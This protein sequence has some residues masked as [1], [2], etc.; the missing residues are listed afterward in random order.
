MLFSVIVIVMAAN[1]G[2][3]VVRMIKTKDFKKTSVQSAGLSV[4]S[5]VLECI[6]WKIQSSDSSDGLYQIFG[7]FYFGIAFVISVV[8]NIQIISSM[9]KKFSR[10]IKS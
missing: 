9:K 5:L 4:L 6:W 2:F 7:Y 3:T 1:I 10:D 8:I